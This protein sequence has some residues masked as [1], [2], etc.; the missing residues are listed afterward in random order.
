MRLKIILIKQWNLKFQSLRAGPEINRT[1]VFTRSEG[2]A[3]IIQTT[4]P[5]ASQPVISFFA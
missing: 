4:M 2:V 1:L 5:F 3:Q